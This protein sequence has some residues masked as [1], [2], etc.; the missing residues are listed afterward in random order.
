MSKSNSTKFSNIYLTTPP[1]EIQIL[2]NRAITDS[3]YDIYPNESRPGITNLFTIL[4]AMENRPLNELV[5]E[6]KG[7]TPKMFKQ[8]VAESVIK[9]LSD[10]QRRYDEVKGNS[11]WIQ[12]MRQQGNERAQKIARERMGKIREVIGFPPQS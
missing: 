9:G 11:V 7:Y 8:W 2:I 3:I 12:R 1:A 5:E 6:V 10:V 4:S